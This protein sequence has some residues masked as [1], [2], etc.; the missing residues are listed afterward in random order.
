VQQETETLF[1]AGVHGP[2]MMSRLLI[3][4]LIFLTAISLKNNESLLEIPR[5]RQ[6]EYGEFRALGLSGASG[7][8]AG[9]ALV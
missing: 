7:G 3:S 1:Q 9:A 6:P 8:G 4:K 2:M 5:G